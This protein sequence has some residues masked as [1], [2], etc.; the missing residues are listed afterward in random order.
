MPRW[1]ATGPKP[2]TRF[3]WVCSRQLYGRQF[4]EIDGPDGHKHAVHK[5]C[6]KYNGDSDNGNAEYDYDEEG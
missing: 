2:S 3:C 5:S 1:K 4:A 6:A